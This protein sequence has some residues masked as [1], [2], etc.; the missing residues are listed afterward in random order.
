MNRMTIKRTESDSHSLLWEYGIK[1]LLKYRK[2]SY[3][4]IGVTVIVTLAYCL[5]LPNQYT[6]TA[7]ILPG[8]NNNTL[9]GLKDLAAGSLGELGLESF[10]SAD[11]TSSAL[12]PQILR[13][14]LIS[15]KILGKMYNF[16]HNNEPLSI[17][18]YEYLKQPIPDKAIRKLHSIVGISTDRKTGLISLSVTTE[19]PELSA[20]MISA[21]LT[22]LDE[23]NKTY[24]NSKA[25]QKEQFI[26]EQLVQAKSDLRNA[27]KDLMT[28]QSQNRNYATSDDPM[29]VNQFADLKRNVSIKETVF[30]TLTKQHELARV[31]SAGDM[32]V[33]N[34]LDH[35]SVPLVK[36]APRRSLYMLSA[37]FMAGFISLLLSVWREHNN[38][39]INKNR[40]H[41]LIHDNSYNMNRLER[42]VLNTITTFTDN[43]ET[44]KA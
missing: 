34:I 44:T 17:T 24:R 7:S 6:S 16:T 23:Y 38:R 4:I 19:Y 29:L 37:F 18:G 2:M 31:E 35:G 1:P 30:L 11:E 20:K 12:Y 42:T 40:L 27:E 13:S 15:E 14:R 3:L 26:S 33:I 32:P 25:K 9:S 8:G 28:F 39:R 36:S 43:K 41:E 10:V 21:Y 5:L 22:E